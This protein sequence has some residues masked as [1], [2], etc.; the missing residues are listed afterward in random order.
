MKLV[1]REARLLDELLLAAAQGV[2]QSN[3]TTVEL[4]LGT[5]LVGGRIDAG[6]DPQTRPFRLVAPGGTARLLTLRE[7]PVEGGA[8]PALLSADSVEFF[9]RKASS[10]LDARLVLALALMRSREGDLA[11]ARAHAVSGPLPSGDALVDELQARLASDPA[12][13]ADARARGEALSKLRLLSRELESGARDP[14]LGKRIDDFLAAYGRALEPDELNRL[15]AERAKLIDSTRPATLEDFATTFRLPSSAVSFESSGR[16]SLRFSF[17][18]R[19]S[20]SFERGEWVAD[21][22]GWT[23]ETAARGDAEFLARP[24]PSL[25]LVDPLRTSNTTL[26]VVLTLEQPASTRAELVVISIAGFHFAFRGAGDGKSGARVIADTGELERLLARVRAGE[27]AP[28]SGWSQGQTVELHFVVQR[29]SRSAQ[30]E[31]DGRRVLDPKFPT[32][33]AEAGE[34]RL[35][36][37]AW[38]RVRLRAV[39]IESGRR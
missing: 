33:P 38:E 20:G 9:A 14:T 7:S 32:P 29:A 31:V 15:H 16:V 5:V 34:P 25:E 30:V 3:G 6:V 10:P 39:E 2:R 26:D 36:V 22:V 4:H 24:S 8:A 21:G 27:G 1:E 19:E 37:R 13:S 28:F 35:I 17:D 18:G 23:P 11:G 12:P